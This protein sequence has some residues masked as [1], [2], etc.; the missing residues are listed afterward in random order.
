MIV[1]DASVAVKWLFDETNSES[2][3]SLLDQSSRLIAPS[4]IRLEVAGAV[5]WRFRDGRI[6]YDAARAA[7]DTWDDMLKRGILDL[8]PI[9][10]VYPRAVDLALRVKHTIPDCLYVIAAQDHEAT[11][12]TADQPM[13]ERCSPAYSRISLLDATTSATLVAR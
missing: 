3:L 10:D 2:A 5:L 4:I 11:V 7:C 12:I 13:H 1:V 6:S 8:V 9:E